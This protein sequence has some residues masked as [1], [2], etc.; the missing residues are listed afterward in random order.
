LLE[1]GGPGRCPS[2]DLSI[3]STGVE[4]SFG[5]VVKAPLPVMTGRRD[6]FLRPTSAN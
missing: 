1:A 6:D 5:N 2:D 4:N 3:K